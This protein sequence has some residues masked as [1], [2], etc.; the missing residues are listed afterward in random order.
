[1]TAGSL[2]S[3]G[4]A[5]TAGTARIPPFHDMPGSEAPKEKGKVQLFMSQLRKLIIV[6]VTA[7]T[8]CGCGG[9]DFR[10]VLE[11]PN[12]NLTLYV[13]NQSFAKPTVDISASIDDRSILTG[14]FEVEQQHSWSVYSIRLTPGQHVI[15]AQADRGVFKLERSFVVANQHWA[16]LQF[17]DRPAGGSAPNKHGLS[18][19]IS[20]EPIR[21][22]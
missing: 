13:S 4:W 11:E 15:R 10:Y 6:A 17:W 9:P 3:R 2:E 19:E 5:G 1:L 22:L 18:F 8:I 20:S 7:L 16:V 14:E 12:A 21:F